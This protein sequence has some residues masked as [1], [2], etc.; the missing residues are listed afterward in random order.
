M[1]FNMAAGIARYLASMHCFAREDN[2]AVLTV[3]AA[4]K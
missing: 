3:I 1:T 4:V 2:I